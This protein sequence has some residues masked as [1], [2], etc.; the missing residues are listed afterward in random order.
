VKIPLL[1]YFIGFI[2]NKV[3]AYFTTRFGNPVLLFGPKLFLENSH[4]FHEHLPFLWHPEGDV[5]QT[6]TFLLN[7][8]QP[9]LNGISLP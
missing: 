2:A 1:K 3:V 8:T 4:G 9:N 7:K 6:I 5:V